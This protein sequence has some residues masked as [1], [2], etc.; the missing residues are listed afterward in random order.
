MERKN[1]LIV[2]ATSKRFH[3]TFNLSFSNQI[4]IKK[5]IAQSANAIN[6][7]KLLIPSRMIRSRNR[8]I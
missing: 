5:N 2:L 6:I 8:K 3:C 1:G 7:E 4:S